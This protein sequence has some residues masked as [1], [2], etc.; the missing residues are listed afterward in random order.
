MIQKNL[1]RICPALTQL[2]LEPLCLLL[3]VDPL[4][5]VVLEL[6]DERVVRLPRPRGLDLGLALLGRN[7]I[8]FQQTVQRE[9]QQSV[10]YSCSQLK[11]C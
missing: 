2:Y 4:P 5:D 9:F 3:R 11:Y 8:E 1:I 7:S 6:R 10:Q